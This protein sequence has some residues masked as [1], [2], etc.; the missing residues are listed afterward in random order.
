[1]GKRTPNEGLQEIKQKAQ[2]VEGVLQRHT[3]DFER[4]ESAGMTRSE[5]S[6]YESIVKDIKNDL[7]GLRD[8][9][10]GFWEKLKQKGEDWL[11]KHTNKLSADKFAEGYAWYHDMP[12][13]LALYKVAS[14]N[15]NY[16][17]EYIQKNGYLY[18]SISDLHNYKLENDIRA[19]IKQETDKDDC[20]VLVLNSDS[21][22][23]QAIQ[24]S[25]EFQ[26]F[27]RQNISNIRQNGSIPDTK[28]EFSNIDKD[29]YSTLHGAIVKDI[30]LD[31]QGNLTLR[32]EDFYNFNKGRTSGKGQLG[33]RLQNEG[34]LENYYVIIL[35]KI[36]NI[37]V[38]K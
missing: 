24:S 31:S 38:T 5:I 26:R 29:L 6:K 21:S 30:Q 11:V 23:S 34:K 17:Q 8:L 7:Q 12:E 18:D 28:I 16:N 37:E 15:L 22:I 1:M 32:I 35:I 20:K 10:Y 4:V 27:I 36:P 14:P 19:R 13:A 33:E 9:V 3:G 2:E 25:Q